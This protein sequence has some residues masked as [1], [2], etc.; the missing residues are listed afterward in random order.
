MSIARLQACPWSHWIW[1]LLFPYLN[2]YSQCLD[3]DW[4]C[5]QGHLHC[6]AINI[7]LFIFWTNT[8]D[9]GG[10]ELPSNFFIFNIISC[11]LPFLLNCLCFPRNICSLTSS[12]E[13][14]FFFPY[15]K[16]RFFSTHTFQGCCC[17]TKSHD[18]F[19]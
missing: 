7:V 16:H 3:V 2:S 13:S 15:N 19:K 5:M 1:Y 10:Q 8:L 6:L 11:L 4:N 9:Q 17:S 18:T 12:I 14:Y